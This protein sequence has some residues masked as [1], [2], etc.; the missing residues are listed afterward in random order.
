VRAL[1]GPLGLA[2]R[3]GTA[4]SPRRLAAERVFWGYGSRAPINSP[5][6]RAKGPGRSSRRLVERDR[7]FERGYSLL[8]RVVFRREGRKHG[9]DALNR[10]S[11]C[12]LRAPRLPG[13]SY[14]CR[15]VG[16]PGALPSAVW[17][18]ANWSGGSGYAARHRGSRPWCSISQR[19]PLRH[20]PRP[21]VQESAV[22]SLKSSL[23][24]PE[25]V[26]FL[27]KR[28]NPIA[29]AVANDSIRFANKVADR[30]HRVVGL[31]QLAIKLQYR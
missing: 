29:N 14:C 23:R 30:R 15:K 12:R 8:L 25:F 10:T 24:P 5:Y 26:L 16:E 7:L 3:V 22:E 18:A 19:H 27:G 28:I 17:E 11:P 9:F 4:L 6:T 20:D 31:R 1:A 2:K 21:G 13:N